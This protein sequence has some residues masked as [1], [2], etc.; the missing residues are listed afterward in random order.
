M[1]INRYDLIEVSN[2]IEAQTAM[3][4]LDKVVA[5]FSRMILIDTTIQGKATKALFPIVHYDITEAIE[6]YKERI[7]TAHPRWTSRMKLITKDLINAE[8]K[9]QRNRDDKKSC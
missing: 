6:R 8:R 1:F 3:L 4:R 2:K 7:K 9:I 5:S